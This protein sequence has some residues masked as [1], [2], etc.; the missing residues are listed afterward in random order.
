MFL[1]RI[2]WKGLARAFSVRRSAGL[3]R[4]SEEEL[5]T[6]SAAGA[7][8][9]DIRLGTEFAQ[10]HFPGSLNVGLAGRSFAV[11]V[12]LFLPKHS[13]IL[14]VADNAENAGKAQLELAR[15]GFDQVRGFIGIDDLTELH[16]LTQLSVFDLKSTLSRGGKPAILDV[17][18]PGEWKL[19]AIPGSRNIP[20]EQLTSRISELSNSTPLVVVCQGGYQ[21][22]VASSWLQANGF[23]S[24]HHL[25]GGMEAYTSAPYNECIEALSFCPVHPG[26]AALQL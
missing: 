7:V 2:R 8:V 15:A 21:S 23:D 10:G 24:I 20:L 19:Q 26:S 5:K 11:C 16:Q 3:V 1:K 14:L 25:L 9:I 4:I 17:R 6:R 12:G 18:S 13:Q 22:A